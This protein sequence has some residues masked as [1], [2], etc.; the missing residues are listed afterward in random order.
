MASH[1]QPTP[2]PDLVAYLAVPDAAEALRF[3]SQA[4]GARELFRLTAPDGK[5]G[6]AEMV[7]GDS[8][9]ML[10]DEYPDFGSVAPGSLGGSPVKFQL[11]AD[12]VDAFTEAAVAAGATLLRPPKDEFHGHRQSMVACPFGYN[13][14]VSCQ[15]EDVSPEEMQRRFAA[16]FD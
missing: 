10:A 6:H 13:W 2:V 14:F 5:I 8:R 15:I 3:Y 12:D 1:D 4:F 7:I 9:L 11:R 16:A